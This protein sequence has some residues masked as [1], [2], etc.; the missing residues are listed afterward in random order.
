MPDTL[1]QTALRLRLV[2]IKVSNLKGSSPEITLT[3]EVDR[4]DDFDEGTDHEGDSY[5]GGERQIQ[6]AFDG[7]ESGS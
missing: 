6:A 1:I 4:G 2:E 7:G 3:T 5:D